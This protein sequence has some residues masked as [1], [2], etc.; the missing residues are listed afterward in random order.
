M[1]TYCNDTCYSLTTLEIQILGR[2]HIEVL[3]VLNGYENIDSNACVVFKIK[4]K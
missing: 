3:N 2:D 4:V 1:K